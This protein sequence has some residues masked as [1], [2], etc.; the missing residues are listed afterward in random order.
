MGNRDDPVYDWKFD[1]LADMADA[2]EKEVAG[3]EK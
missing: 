2:V 1:T 3:M